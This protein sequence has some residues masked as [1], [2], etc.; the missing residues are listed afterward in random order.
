M[1]TNKKQS[2]SSTHVSVTQWVLKVHWGDFEMRKIHWGRVFSHW[3]KKINNF[4][5]PGKVKYLDFSLGLLDL[6]LLKNQISPGF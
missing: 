3:V 2:C 1:K 6:A 5:T 4:L